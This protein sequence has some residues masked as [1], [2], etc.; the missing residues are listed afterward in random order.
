MVT[1]TEMVKVLV[2]VTITIIETV[3]VLIT[4]TLIEKLIVTDAPEIIAKSLKHNILIF[5]YKNHAFG[6]LIISNRLSI[7][8]L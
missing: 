4:V 8:K 2:T 7:Q 6:I 5:W 3:N 1:V